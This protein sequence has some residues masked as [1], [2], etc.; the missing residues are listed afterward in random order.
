[1]CRRSEGDLKLRVQFWRFENCRRLRGVLVSQS[2]QK[3]S[4]VCEERPGSRGVLRVASRRANEGG[5]M[6][7]LPGETL[8][9]PARR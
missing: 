3:R 4:A 1:M 5:T 7:D 6:L 9:R 8:N 2:E